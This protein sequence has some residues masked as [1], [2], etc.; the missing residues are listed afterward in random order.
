MN[1]IVPRIVIMVLIL[2]LILF[3]ISDD[4]GCCF[5]FLYSIFGGLVII[6]NIKLD[7][8]FN[9]IRV[10]AIDLLNIFVRCVI[11][12]IKEVYFVTAISFVLFVLY[13][14]IIYALLGEPDMILKMYR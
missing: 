3:S 5:S 14:F 6:I 9:A 8:I 12:N 11:V 13:L 2:F 4:N 1:I 7:I 10:I